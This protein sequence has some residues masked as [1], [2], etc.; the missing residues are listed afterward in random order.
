MFNFELFE[1]GKLFVFVMLGMWILSQEIF[2]IN[3]LRGLVR[4][5]NQDFII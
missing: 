4:E 3:C 5:I 1:M 2:K